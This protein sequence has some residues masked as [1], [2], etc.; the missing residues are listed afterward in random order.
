MKQLFLN[1]F[2]LGFLLLY[3]AA[4]IVLYI[5]FQ[6]PLKD[7]LSVL[8]AF[9]IVLPLLALAV[10]RH[11]PA[12][13]ERPAFKKEWVILT[14]LVLFFVWYVTYGSAFINQLIPASI[15]GSPRGMALAILIKKLFVFV[16]VPFI[17]YRSVGFSLPDLGFIVNRISLFSSRNI[18]IILLLGVTAILY[19]YYF[20][21]GA[22]PVREGQF[23]FHQLIITLPLLFLWLCI[24]AGLVEEFFFRIILQSRIAVLFKSPA[25]GIFISALIFG[26]A[27][28]P[29]LYLR[30]AESEGIS[31]QLP[32]YFWSA[33]TVCYMSLAGL[34]LGIIRYRT[35]NIYLLIILHALVDLL[36][37]AKE[38]ISTWHIV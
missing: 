15:T 24:E 30:G 37:N 6:Q 26:L 31:E 7:L 2:G 10:T 3:A 23:S 4:A 27:H 20:S 13:A 18:F 5:N 8:I 16:L 25:A 1:K 29:G 21:G 11:M 33:Y 35:N 19:Q 14:S 9:G 22:A 34:F 28:A 38:F 36:P 17:I 12:P 32:F